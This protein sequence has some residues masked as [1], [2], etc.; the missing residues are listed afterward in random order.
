MAIKYIITGMQYPFLSFYLEFW[1]ADCLNRPH[2]VSQLIW[3]VSLE[4]TFLCAEPVLLYISNET[5][6]DIS[7][8]SWFAGAGKA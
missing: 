1:Y 6:S 4:T 5:S 7:W 2:F 3:F 8:Y